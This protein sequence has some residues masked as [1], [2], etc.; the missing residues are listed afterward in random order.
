MTKLKITS[1]SEA[2]IITKLVYPPYIF[3]TLIVSSV[4]YSKQE[5]HSPSQLAVASMTDNDPRDD[6]VD[7]LL[8]GFNQ[9]ELRTA[10]EFLTNWLPFLSKD[11]CQHCSSKLADRVRSVATGTHL[12]ALSV[13]FPPKI[14]ARKLC[15]CKIDSI[16]YVL[17]S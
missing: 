7:P 11:L 9:S 8:A 14:R 6:P 16:F 1:I 5:T 2:F 10:S 17:N 4:F 12:F 15:N 3:L 13:C